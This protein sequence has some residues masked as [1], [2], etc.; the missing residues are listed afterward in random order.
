MRVRRAKRDALLAKSLLSV[1]DSKLG[2]WDNA[3]KQNEHIR[4]DF[5][6]SAQFNIKAADPAVVARLQAATG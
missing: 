3:S 6:M 1:A 2:M 4:K 5:Y